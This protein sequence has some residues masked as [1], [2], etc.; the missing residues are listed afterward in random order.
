MAFSQEVAVEDHVFRAFAAGARKF[1]LSAAEDRVLLP[2]FGARQVPPVAVA[3][4][5]RHV[6]L[7]DVA[8][9][10][11]VKLIAQA[12]QRSHFGLGVGVFS[13]EVGGD[14]GI[15]L[16][17]EPGVVVDEDGP[18]KLNFS[19]LAVGGGGS[20][21]AHFLLSVVRSEAGLKI[22]SEEAGSR[23]IL[24]GLPTLEW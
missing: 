16:V 4:G 15:F 12:R 5:N 2:L 24:A 22:S 10:L 13:L 18:V 11:F 19:V 3:E 8:E 14:F 21:L 1:C 20:I 7:L 6:G 17:A 9:H 23:T